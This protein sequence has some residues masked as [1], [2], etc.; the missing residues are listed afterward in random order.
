ME[1]LPICKYF[2]FH[3][4]H[5]DML[6]VK[7]MI[8]VSLVRCSFCQII[9]SS[10]SSY[11]ERSKQTPTMIDSKNKVHSYH[12]QH[13]IYKQ[14]LHSKP[15]SSSFLLVVAPSAM[16][17]AFCALH[18]RSKSQVVEA[19]TNDNSDVDRYCG[20][21]GISKI[22]V[23]N[24]NTT[25]S[26]TDSFKPFYAT[27]GLPSVRPIPLSFPCVIPQQYPRYQ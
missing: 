17:L 25:I 13:L 7:V 26:M 24:P 22:L 2:D 3:L 14:Y 15:I 18:L 23:I 16:S 10:R 21:I 9:Y 8:F 19:K 6:E 27:L 20:I 12:F 11:S 5:R 1:P 4:S